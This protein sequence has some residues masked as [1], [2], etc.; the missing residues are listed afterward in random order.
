MISAITASSSVTQAASTSRSVSLAASGSS[1][2]KSVVNNSGMS[3]D[4]IREMFD[5]L[6]I[7]IELARIIT[8][9]ADL[10]IFDYFARWN[11]ANR[12]CSIQQTQVN[13]GTWAFKKLNRN[14]MVD[15]FIAKSTFHRLTAAFG[16]IVKNPAYSNM[17]NW[18]DSVGT[19]PDSIVMWGVE[20]DVY[21]LEHLA[22]WVKYEGS[23][24]KK[25]KSHKKKGNT[26]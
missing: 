20:E 16:P 8:P 22:T 13:A 17:V 14:I 4:E 5:F 10:T 2:K 21:T 1:A 6:E 11:A 25:N 18:L 12:A 24:V 3:H 15:H 7:D 26:K 23:L 19:H 9:P